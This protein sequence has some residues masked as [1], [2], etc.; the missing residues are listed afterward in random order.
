MPEVDTL[1]ED[2]AK[3]EEDIRLLLQGFANK[4]PVRIESIQFFEFDMQRTGEPR[5]NGHQVI[6]E[7]TVRIMI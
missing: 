4:Y 3:L 2:R 1:K 7:L 6:S 5:N